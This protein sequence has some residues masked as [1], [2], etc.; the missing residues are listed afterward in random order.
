MKIKISVIDNSGKNY[1]GEIEL[2]QTKSGTKLQKAGTKNWYNPGTTVEK[3]INLANE[4]FF[5]KPETITDIIE[6]L[7]SKDFHYKSTDLTLP[8]RKIVRNNVIKKTKNLPDGTISKQWTYIK[9]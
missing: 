8:L 1:E 4:G 9:S 2:P 5:D 7:K 3:I 6:E